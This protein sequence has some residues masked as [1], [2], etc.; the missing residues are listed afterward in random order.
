MNRCEAMHQPKQDA[1]GFI[2]SSTP[3]L[4]G[5]T[6]ESQPATQLILTTD[7]DPPQDRGS[8]TFFSSSSAFKVPN[9]S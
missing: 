1:Q 3:R 7:N 4:Q 6:L 8:D 2:S 9:S 5:D